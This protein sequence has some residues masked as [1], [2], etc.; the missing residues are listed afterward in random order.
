[1][2][3]RI[4]LAAGLVLLLAALGVTLAQS[5][6]RA[7]GSNHVPEIEEAVELG[8]GGGSHCQDGETIPGNSAALRLLIGTYGR[9]VP[10]LGVSA[11][12]M[13]GDRV[14]AGERPGGGS[15]GRID[16]PVERVEDAVSGVRVCVRAGGPGRSVLY[17]AGG[18]V[19]FEWMR[20]GSESWFELLPTIAHRFGLGRASLAGSLLLPF[21]ALLLLAAWAATIRVVLRE[22]GS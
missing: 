12:R 18:R 9:P 2:A 17:G 5:A 15:A 7:A 20:P 11:R 6:S 1:M 21:V 22:A 14:T 13:G 19:R 4:A 3:V 8:R 16:I 10:E